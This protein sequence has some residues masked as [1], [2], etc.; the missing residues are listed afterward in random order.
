[1]HRIQYSPKDNRLTE[2]SRKYLACHGKTIFVQ[3]QRQGE[4]KALRSFVFGTS[5][6]GRPIFI[7]D[8]ARAC[9]RQIVKKNAFPKVE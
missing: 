8:S 6:F 4:P 2:V 9:T 7:S 1:M 5:L 3:H